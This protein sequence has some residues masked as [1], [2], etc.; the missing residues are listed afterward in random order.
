MTK[1]ALPAATRRR[2]DTRKGP[3]CQRKQLQMLC[4]NGVQ[5]NLPPDYNAPV[6]TLA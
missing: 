6:A 2:R 1:A 3:A 4:E 5:P